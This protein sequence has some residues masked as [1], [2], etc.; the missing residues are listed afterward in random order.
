MPTDESYMSLALELAREAAKLG[1]VPVG[2]V[3]VWDGEV[4]GTGFN[5]R[6]TGKNALAHA[7]LEAIDAA[8]RR[9]GGWR[10][11]RCDLYVTLEPCPMCAGAIVNA[12]I[13]RVVFGARD[14]KAGCFG[15]VSD[16][17]ALPFN[18]RPEVVGGVLA[19]A[20][21][22]ELSAFFQRLRNCR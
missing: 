13:R 21:A 3:A 10:L 6:E 11:H 1:E 14:P 2:A 4:V 17:A 15:S 12:R 9:L 19:E 20:C 8:C 5:R 22:A 16:F 18:H 7:E